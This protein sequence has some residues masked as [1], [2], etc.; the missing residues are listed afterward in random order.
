MTHSIGIGIVGL[1][2]MG[3]THLAAYHKAIAAGYNCHIAAICDRSPEQL[4]TTTTAGNIDTTSSLPD[5]HHIDLRTTAVY[6]DYLALLDDPA[7]ELISICTHTTTHVPMTLAALD[8]NK[9]VLVEK[10]LALTSHD[11]QRVVDAAS[12]SKT[13]CMPAMCMRFWPAWRYLHDA[14]ADGR[15]GKVQSL[16]FHRLGSMP[17]WSRFYAEISQSGGAI[18]DLHIHDVDFI[19]WCCGLPKAVYAAGSANHLSAHFIYPDIPHIV[20]EGGWA[21]DPAFPF[22]MRFVACFE[23]A[24]L[25]FLL[26]RPHELMIS[27]NDQSQA[28]ELDTATGY[29][30]EIRHMLECIADGKTQAEVTPDDAVNDLRIIEAEQQCLAQRSL[31]RCA[32]DIE[33]T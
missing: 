33:P 26:G 9:H 28:I 8:A 16:T 31:T 11:A 10:P 14:I 7:V 29:D 1:G 15:Y 17:T 21:Q 27:Q 12:R 32:V 25:D 22:T 4:T 24:T 2:F 23:N 30:N 19:T 6:N 13:I 20:A 3:H 5:Q 18:I